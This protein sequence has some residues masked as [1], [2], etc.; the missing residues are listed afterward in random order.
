MSRKLLSVLL[1]T[2]ML[3]SFTLV[4]QAQNADCQGDVTLTYWHHWG[5]NRIPI[6]ESVIAAFE[7]ANPG[8]CVNNIFLPWDNRLPNLLTA[9]AAGRDDVR[10]PG[11]AFLRGHRVDHPAG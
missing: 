4:A 5:G 3:L 8:I 1:L 11:P 7:V 6:M 2:T 10:P 9:I